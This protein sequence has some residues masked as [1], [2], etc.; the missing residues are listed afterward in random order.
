M[1]DTV[2]ASTI[3]L[4]RR[5]SNGET[6]IDYL[7]AFG[8][9]DIQIFIES[10]CREM[11]LSNSHIFFEKC[12]IV[13]EGQS[14]VNY[15]PIAYKKIYESSMAEDGISLINL[16]GNGS[17]INFLKLL[18]RNKRDLTLLFLDKDSI[19]VNKEKL[20]INSNIIFDGLI[21]EEYNKFID[22]FIDSQT[23]F[24]GDKEFEDT[25]SNDIFVEILTKYRPKKNSYPWSSTEIE[26]LRDTGKFSDRI[27]KIV[28]EN[29]NPLSI[30]KPEL[31][32]MLATETKTED[33][34]SSIIELF[35]KARA[36]AK[37]VEI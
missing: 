7:N 36:I 35:T 9:A 12:F 26:A 32:I 2:P 11:G 17:A 24:I 34:P 25:F 18:M 4:L 5:H 23:V 20:K 37:I 3:N 33:I 13:V 1:V 30:K 21:E 8:D 19:H 29:C 28:W 16:E 15:L 31:G 10:M 6:K 27:V 14:E 22:N